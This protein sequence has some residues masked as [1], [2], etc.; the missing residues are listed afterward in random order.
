MKGGNTEGI[1]VRC[2]CR[3]ALIVEKTLMD[4]S[5]RISYIYVCTG[6][7]RTKRPIC[8]I[9][10]SKN[11]GGGLKLSIHRHMHSNN[12]NDRIISINDRRH[13]RKNR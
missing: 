4:G 10:V 8:D 12:S 9:T 13:R 2:G 3:L 6:C 5:R 11:R 7:R 1:C